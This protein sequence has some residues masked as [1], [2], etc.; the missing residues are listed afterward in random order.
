[1]PRP[2]KYVTRSDLGW[3]ASP[4]SSA[5]PKSGLVIHYD[6]GDQGLAAKPHSDCI[7]YWKNTREFHTGPSRGWADIGYSFM[8]CP[9]GYVLE[10]RGLYKQQAAQPGG[11]STYY[12]CTLATGPG[13]PITDEQVDAVRELRLWLMEPDTSIAGTVKGHRD[14]ISTSCPGDAAYAMVENGTFTKSPGSGGGSLE[15]D[16]VGLREGDSGERVKFLQEVLVKGGHSVGG[17]GIDGDYGPNTSKAVLA[18]RKAEGSKQNFGDRITG[19]AAKQIMSQ[20]IKA[21]L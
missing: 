1:M 15:D 13:D 11:N 20:F 19:A 10:G 18:A 9:H 8:S 6:S 7:T 14:F 2:Q 16:M 3:G 12:S 17:S 4:A 5:D 21:H